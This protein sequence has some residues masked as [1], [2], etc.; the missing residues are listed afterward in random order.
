MSEPLLDVRDL[1]VS[2]RTENGIVRAVD[3][4]SFTLEAGHVLGIVGESGS[5][6]SVT[7]MSIMQ[8]IRDPNAIFE[9]QVRYKGRDLMGLSQSQMQQRARRRD[10][11]DL[12][13]P[14]DLAEPGLQD[15]LAD[16]GDAARARAAHAP[17]RA[18][19][20]RGPARRRSASRAPRGGSTTTRTSSLAACGSA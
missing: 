15:R 13:G 2:F 5:G 1:R 6:K 10:R 19:A 3:G 12:P 14:D 16:R 20:C 18:R 7:V 9:G 17:R 8:L 4:V 11:D